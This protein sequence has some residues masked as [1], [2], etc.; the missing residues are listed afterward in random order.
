MPIRRLI[1]S[2]ASVT[3]REEAAKTTTVSPGGAATEVMYHS[4]TSQILTGQGG[5]EV[6]CAT[7]FH[8]SSDE[9][10]ETACTPEQM[11]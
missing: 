5:E 1:G 6:T 8:E 3:G 4:L 10:H 9:S 11:V 7:P 2:A